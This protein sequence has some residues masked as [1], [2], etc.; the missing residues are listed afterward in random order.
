MQ[1]EKRS[2]INHLLSYKKVNVSKFSSNQEGLYD[3][4]EIDM[5]YFKKNVKNAL[6]VSENITIVKS[7]IFL[8]KITF[9]NIDFSNA[10][11]S[12]SVFDRCIFINCKFKK[13]NFSD[14]RFIGVK[15]N[16]C[17][18]FDTNFRRTS[19]SDRIG[20]SLGEFVRCKFIKC[21]LEKTAYAFPIF[22]DV[23]FENCNLKLID[24]NGSRFENCKFIGILD[25]VRFRGIGID[26]KTEFF[27]WNR[28]NP[29]K[30]SNKMINI[31]FSEAQLVAT[32]FSHYINLDKI[33][34][35]FNSSNYVI[36]TNHIQKINNFITNINSNTLNWTQFER[37]RA[38]SI[39]NMFLTPQYLNQDS[40]FIDK[41]YLAE[42]DNQEL[43]DKVFNNLSSL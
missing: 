4:T 1:E 32:T 33:I 37:E 29:K 28:F 9:E 6:L 22:K 23:F 2:L 26:F 15:F 42:F 36:L 25:D 14:S 13:T 38:I 10:N 21:N 40:L 3:L 41:I 18:F 12:K 39:L 16:D 11:L 43:I 30:Y 7:H 17:V 19:M 34:F 35:P 31:D 27:F 5:E 20:I 24:F 8:Q